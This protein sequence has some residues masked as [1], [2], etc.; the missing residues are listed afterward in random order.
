MQTKNR[1]P[2]SQ[3][4]NQRI[5]L[6]KTSSQERNQ[7]KALLDLAAARLVKIRFTH[8]IKWLDRL[9]S[10][11]SFS[12]HLLLEMKKM[13]RPTTSYDDGPL[14]GIGSLF[15]WLSLFL[16]AFSL[17]LFWTTWRRVLL[18]SLFCTFGARSQDPPSAEAREAVRLVSRN[19]SSTACLEGKR[20]VWIRKYTQFFLD[21]HN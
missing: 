14:D 11:I 1:K 18:T 21:R 15:P 13:H 17:L 4:R 8:T 12:I 6:R 7:R 9:E 16:D 3:E 19:I 10:A 20:N 5:L 2:S